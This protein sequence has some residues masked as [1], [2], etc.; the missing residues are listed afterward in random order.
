MRILMTGASGYLGHAMAERLGREHDVWAVVRRAGSAPSRVREITADLVDRQLDFD[1]WPPQVDAVLH[2]AQ[3]RLYGDFPKAALDVFEVNV[4]ATARLLDYALRA[5]ARTFCLISSG[6]VYEPYGG[7]LTEDQHLHPSSINGAS[8]LAAEALAFAYRGHMRVSALRLFFPYG[9]GQSHRF[10]P[11]I[12][13]RVV[14]QDVVKLDGENGLRFSPIYVDDVADVTMHALVEGWDGAVNVA[15]SE[16]ITLRD[17]AEGIG[18]LSGIKPRFQ[19]TNRPSIDVVADT[20]LFRSLT[21]GSMF[22]PFNV[23]LERVLAA[24]QSSG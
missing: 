18:R 9:P 8:K 4:G 6:S 22:T 5:D 7:P 21:D 23:G 24:F 10:L 17:L 1:G 16:H 2:A 12:V 20:R 15:G 14:R 13:E 19:Q 11:N 3:S